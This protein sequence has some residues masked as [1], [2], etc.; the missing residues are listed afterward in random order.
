MTEKQ[1]VTGLKVGDILVNTDDEKNISFYKVTRLKGRC[2][3]IAHL[4][5]IGVT[6]AGRIGPYLGG[7]KKMTVRPIDKFAMYDPQNP[8]DAEFEDKY[9]RVRTRKNK[10]TGEYRLCN[11]WE[12]YDSG[13]EY[14]GAC[15][16]ELVEF[17]YF[18]MYLA[19]PELREEF[20][21]GWRFPSARISCVNGDVLPLNTD[22]TRLDIEL[23]IEIPYPTNDDTPI[24]RK[25][26]HIK[27]LTE[28]F[29]KYRESEFLN[30][31]FRLKEF[32]PPEIC[33]EQVCT[34][35]EYINWREAQLKTEE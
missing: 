33:S 4:L 35:T 2:E 14:I 1:N 11:G 3:A 22:W 25:R 30:S 13:K 34:L 21:G 7:W 6:E 23:E 18:F 32:K 29:V 20:T 19:Q 5:C 12:L 9:F 16:W 24:F 10:S 8:P 31:R 28:Y 17:I 27:Q 15:D 26:E